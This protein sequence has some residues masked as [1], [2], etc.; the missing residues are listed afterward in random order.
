MY[1]YLLVEFLT[2]EVLAQTRE[3]DMRARLM[4]VSLSS[5]HHKSF[6]KRLQTFDLLPL[7]VKQTMERMD[8][9][10]D[11]SPQ[12]RRL[13]S[14]FA[15]QDLVGQQKIIVGTCARPFR[16]AVHSARLCRQL[17]SQMHLCSWLARH[18]E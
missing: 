13:S 5:R 11:A 18:L 15:L 10:E 8:T 1:R 17:L 4:S 6:L 2:A 9:K 12:V 7:A 3:R 14:S 16:R